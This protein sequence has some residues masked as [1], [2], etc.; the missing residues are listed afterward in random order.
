MTK[1]TVGLDAAARMMGIS[2]EALRKRIKRG[3]VQARKDAAGRWQVTVDQDTGRDTGGDAGGPLIDQLKSENE[4]LRQQLHQ[5]SIII[6]NLSETVKLLE[7]PAEGK[8]SW[9]K[10]LFGKE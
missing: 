1:Q 3:T 10:R 5:Q 4:F 9:W 7:A 6:Y 2:K 8:K